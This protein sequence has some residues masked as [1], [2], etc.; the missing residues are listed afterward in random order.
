MIRSRL[1]L[2]ALGLC[3]LLLGLMAFASSAAQAEPGAYWSVIKASGELLKIVLGSTLLPKL[4]I[5]EIEKKTAELLFTTKSGTK[6]A[7][8]CT[9]AEFDEGALLIAHGGISLFRIKFLGCITKLNGTISAACKPSGGGTAKG[10]GEILTEKATG[11]ILL[12]KLESGEVDDLVKITPEDKESK[13]SKLFSKIELG[14]ECAI[15]ESVNVEAKTLGEGLWLKDCLGNSSF[16]EYQVEHLI[17][18][19]LAKPSTLLAL[20]QEATI[21]GSALVRLDI[22]TEHKGLKWAGHP[23]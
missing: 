14:P 15:G 23:E 8:L 22:N 17:E 13:T 18:Q 6:V 1:G 21:D 12:D 3:A 11:L 10:S 16:L 7:I 2:K 19:A 20:G 4:E 9:A 5:S